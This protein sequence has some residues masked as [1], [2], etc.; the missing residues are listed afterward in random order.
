MSHLGRI[1]IDVLGSAMFIPRDSRLVIETLFYIQGRQFIL[2][3]ENGILGYF[4]PLG[5]SYGKG[6]KKRWEH[7][8]REEDDSV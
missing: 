8:E 5:G 2:R 3:Q 7:E 4:P 6:G 1:E